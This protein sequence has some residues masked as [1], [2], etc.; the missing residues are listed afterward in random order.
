MCPIAGGNWNNSS[1]AG[2]W[3][4]NSCGKAFNQIRGAFN[5]TFAKCV[6]YALKIN[7]KFPCPHLGRI[8]FTTDGDV[9]RSALI[10]VLLKLVSPMAIFRAVVA[11]IVLAVYGVL[12]TRRQAHVTH[13]CFKRIHPRS[14]NFYTPTPVV[15]VKRCFW[16]CASLLHGVPSFVKRMALYRIWILHTLQSCNGGIALKAAAGLRAAMPQIGGGYVFICTAVAQT[17]PS[18]FATRPPL[19]CA[20]Y[21]QSAKTLACQINR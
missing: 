21:E 15:F 19:A 11:V 18:N 16:I 7:S 13:K 5:P 3:A 20:S 2:V 9:D 17:T 4:L 1:N 6:S 10:A 14:A 12:W 8:G